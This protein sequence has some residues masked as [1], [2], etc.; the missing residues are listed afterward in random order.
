M[1]TVYW[2]QEKLQ[3]VATHNI[4]VCADDMNVLGGNVKYHEEKHSSSIRCT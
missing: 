3:L 4:L 2:N 1:Y